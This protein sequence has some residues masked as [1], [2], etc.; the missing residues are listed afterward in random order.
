MPMVI[1]HPERLD[2]IHPDLMKV[3]MELAEG[4]EFAVLEGLRTIERQRQMV[5]RGSSRTMN[6]RHLTGHAVDLAPLDHGQVSFAWP[7]YYPFAELVKQAAAEV[8]VPIEWG[9]DWESFKDGPHW[10]LPWV[11]YPRVTR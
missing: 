1:L 11:A 9:G 6:S 4:T 2:G 3:V 10:Q 8:Q 5:A 7:L